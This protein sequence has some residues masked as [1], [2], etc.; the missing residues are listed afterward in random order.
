MMCFGAII[1]EPHNELITTTDMIFFS[2]GASDI[3]NVRNQ[4]K[5]SLQNKNNFLPD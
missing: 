3:S 2:L 1:N 5:I 4:Y